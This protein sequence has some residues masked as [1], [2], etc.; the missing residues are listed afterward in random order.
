MLENEQPVLI[1][2]LLED[3]PL[4]LKRDQW[5]DV[6]AHDPRQRQV[7]VSWNEIAEI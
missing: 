2:G 5:L 6:V 4:R 3:P 7:R 1:D